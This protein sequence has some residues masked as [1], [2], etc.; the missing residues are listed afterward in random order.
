M[1]LNK[2]GNR[3]R[4]AHFHI[5]RLKVTVNGRFD[6]AP[7]GFCRLPASRT[8][9]EFQQGWCPLI[10]RLQP[11]QPPRPL[12]SQRRLLLLSRALNYLISS[13]SLPSPWKALTPNYSAN[14]P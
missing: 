8:L 6:T 3:R 14:H 2:Y 12:K 9:T 11:R 10:N 1:L 13:K 5:S 4:E 7:S